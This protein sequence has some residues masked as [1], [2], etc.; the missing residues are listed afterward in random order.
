MIWNS[1]YGTNANLPEISEHHI[2]FFLGL[3]EM[4]VMRFNVMWWFISVKK[5]KE[6]RNNKNE[7]SVRFKY[8]KTAMLK[9]TLLYKF[10]YCCA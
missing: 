7:Q 5:V 8:G 6:I 9:V 4:D 10:T 1:E 2:L 3:M